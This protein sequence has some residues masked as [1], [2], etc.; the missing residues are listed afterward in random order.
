MVGQRVGEHHVLPVED[1]LDGRAVA[2]RLGPQLLARRQ[3][4][5]EEHGVGEHPDAVR[6]LPHRPVGD[7]PGDPG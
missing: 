5:R 6:E 1:R 2:Q 3:V 7:G 4:Q